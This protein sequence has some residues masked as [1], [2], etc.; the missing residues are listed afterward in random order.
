MKWIIKDEICKME[1]I[2]EPLK[3]LAKEMIIRKPKL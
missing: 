2:E 3:V 1:L